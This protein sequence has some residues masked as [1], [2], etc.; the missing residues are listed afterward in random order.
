MADEKKNPI[1]VLQS[2]DL[3]EIGGGEQL[4]IDFREISST[5][6][7]V[8]TIGNGPKEVLTPN[9]DMEELKEKYLKNRKNENDE[10]EK[11]IKIRLFKLTFKQDNKYLVEE[12]VTLEKITEIAKLFI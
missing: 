11:N 3:G 2:F 10:E 6:Y 9:S 5:E 8:V 4:I 7:Y 1:E 12:F